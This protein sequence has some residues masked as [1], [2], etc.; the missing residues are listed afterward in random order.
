MARYSLRFKKPVAKDL[1]NLPKKDVQRILKRIQSLAE[2]PR[3]TGCEKLVDR[4]FYRIR[5]GR[6]RV[7]YEIQDDV[8]VVLVIKVGLRDPC[9]DRSYRDPQIPRQPLRPR[10][11]ARIQI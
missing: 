2:N 3:P 4:E 10:N 7:L 5:Q 6:Y 1:R 11:L 8:L 9:I